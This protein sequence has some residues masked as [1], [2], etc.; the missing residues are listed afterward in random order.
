MRTLTSRTIAVAAAAAIALTAFA[1]QPAA[2]SPRGDAAALAAVGAVFGTIAGII[3]A[4]QARDEP[5]IAY[6]PAYPAYPYGPVYH[7]PVAGWHGD[8]RHHHHS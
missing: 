6:T 3:A 1:A 5:P 4:E 8:W 7:G 2:A